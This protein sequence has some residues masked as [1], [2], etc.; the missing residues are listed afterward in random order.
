LGL[1]HRGDSMGDTTDPTKASHEEAVTDGAEP[2]LTESTIV[3]VDD[4]DSNVALLE[5]I[6]SLHG[7]QHVVGLTDP[8]EALDAIAEQ[9]PDLVLLDLHMPELDGFDVLH[10]LRTSPDPVRRVV[11]VI[12]LTADATTTARRR[13]L[14][15]GAADF[16]TKPFDVVEVALRIRNTLER[17]RLHSVI[18]EQN[19]LLEERVRARTLDL[20]EAYLETFERLALAAE[21]RDDETGQ[22]TKRVGKVAR[23]IGARLGMVTDELDRLERAAGLHDVGKIG[24]P[25]AILLKPGRLTEEEFDVVKTHTTIGARILSGSRSPLMQLAEVIAASHHERWDGKGY[26]ALAGEDI[27]RPARI[28]TL[29]DAFDAMTTDRPYRAARPLHEAL[30]EIRRERGRQFDPEVVDAFLELEPR[31]FWADGAPPRPPVERSSHERR[32]RDFAATEG[33]ARDR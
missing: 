20:A 10:A 25:D 27:P 8:L 11:P 1:G 12:V 30:E 15:G 21:Y 14:A 6:L 3:I 7:Y 5:R 4:E 2:W 13:A 32:L 19:E 26:H 9:A 22:H 33:S 23:V 31:G 28:T 29:A 18:R 17:Q 16:L 24:V